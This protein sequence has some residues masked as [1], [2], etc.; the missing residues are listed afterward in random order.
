[1]R[2]PTA[3]SHNIHNNLNTANE[4]AINLY[5]RTFPFEKPKEDA[6]PKPELKKVREEKTLAL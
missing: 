6:K 5:N 3:K 2:I 4:D 1:M